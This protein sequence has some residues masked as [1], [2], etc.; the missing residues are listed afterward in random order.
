MPVNNYLISFAIPCYNG[1]N[2]LN[3]TLVSI[4][5]EILSLPI[6]YKNKVEIVVV[7]DQSIDATLE[8][9]ESFNVYDFFRF[10]INKKNLGMDLNF[11]NVALQSFGE[12]VW[13]FGQDDI[14]ESE[15]LHYVL[16]II[17]KLKPNIL[18]LNYTQLDKD[19]NIIDSSCLRNIVNGSL[20]KNNIY[21]YNSNVE[22]FNKFYSAPTFL[23][24]TIMKREFWEKFNH[25]PFVGTCYV[26]V[27]C[28]LS[29]LNKGNI[30]V[31]TRNIITGLVPD[32]KWQSNGNQYFRVMLGALRMQNLVYHSD[33]NPL[34]EKIFNLTK[35]RFLA[36]LYFLIGQSIK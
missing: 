24:A 16:E 23:P 30:V 7:D 25:I 15:G 31:M 13:F 33:K 6:Y 5:N 8:I 35:K 12:Y 17:D 10:S 3:T 22:Y 9:L 29:N 1:H 20:Q 18:S 21:H 34:P 14:L 4:V 27:A 32:D 2:S 28:I 36:R 26:Q 11:A 19:G